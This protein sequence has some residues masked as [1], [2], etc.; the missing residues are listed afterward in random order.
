MKNFLVIVAFL[1]SARNIVAI[2]IDIVGTEG[3]VDVASFPLGKCQGDCDRHGKFLRLTNTE[4]M[5]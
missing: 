4:E 2:P 3:N 1:V 5:C